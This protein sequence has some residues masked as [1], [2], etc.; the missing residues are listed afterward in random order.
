[1]EEEFI[2]YIWPLWPKKWRWRSWCK[3][4]FQRWL[5]ATPF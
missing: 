4:L 3:F 2:R 1:M 5:L